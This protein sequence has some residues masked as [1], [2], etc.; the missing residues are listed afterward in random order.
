MQGS[1]SHDLKMTDI[2]Q[3]ALD[4]CGVKW[5]MLRCARIPIHF[6]LFQAFRLVSPFLF[7]DT[8]FVQ[9]PIKG[10]VWETFMEKDQNQMKYV[11]SL[12]VKLKEGSV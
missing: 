9:Q 12:G 8:H 4:I 2:P 7:P 3:L 1:F 5:A 6:Q 11:V 10:C